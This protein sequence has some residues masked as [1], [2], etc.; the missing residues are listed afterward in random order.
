VFF[1]HK[2]HRLR[3]RFRVLFRAEV[4][5]T[6]ADPAEVDAEAAELLATLA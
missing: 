6:V 2:S 1:L 4:A 3:G 5:R